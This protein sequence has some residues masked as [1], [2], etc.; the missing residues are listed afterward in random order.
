MPIT[1]PLAPDTIR[2]FSL[3]A[4]VYGVALIILGVLAITMPGVAT[5]AVSILLGWLLLIAGIVG[6]IAVFT[7]G[8]SAP[9]FWWNLLTA[10]LY[11]LAGGALL[12]RPVAG[13]LTLTIILAAYLLATG[14]LKSIG[15]LEYRQTIPGAW[16]WVLASGL[17]D[18]ALGLIITLGLPGDL[19]MLGLIVGIDLVITGVALVVAAIHCRRQ[20]EASHV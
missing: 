7:A 15:A 3:W 20:P 9:G 16:G 2:K 6:I 19:W 17:V 12:A 13:A 8:P 14:V 4:A 18:I 5:L 11:A 1:L 10:V